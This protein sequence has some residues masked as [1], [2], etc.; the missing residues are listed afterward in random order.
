MQHT[1]SWQM[2]IYY[3]QLNENVISFFAVQMNASLY[4]RSEVCK[5]KLSY[6][7]YVF[8]IE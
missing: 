8:L 6:N 5:T 7:E 4:L 3:Q 2:N 1:W